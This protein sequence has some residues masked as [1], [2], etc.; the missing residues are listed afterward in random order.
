MTAQS[1]RY[2]DPTW[3]EP[4]RLRFPPPAAAAI[5]AIPDVLTPL[6][7]ADRHSSRARLGSLVS[8]RASQ[9]P[10]TCANAEVQSGRREVPMGKKAKQDVHCGRVLAQRKAR[11]RALADRRARGPCSPLVAHGRRPPPL[12]ACMRGL[13][14]VDPVRAAHDADA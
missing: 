9:A 8:Q 13:D 3:H 6:L 10:S 5:P 4:G 7:A 11:H 14:Q 1:K 12:D 2:A